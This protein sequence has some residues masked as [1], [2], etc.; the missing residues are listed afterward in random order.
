[1][2]YIDV[3][4]LFFVGGSLVQEFW[5][6]YGLPRLYYFPPARNEDHRKNGVA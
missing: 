5:I 2:K 1:M 6:Y 4:M 3:H